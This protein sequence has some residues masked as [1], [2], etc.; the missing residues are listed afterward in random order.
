MRLGP[1]DEVGDD[2]K[3]ARIFHPFDDAQLVIEPLAILLI[4]IARAGSKLGQ[5]AGKP[6][7]RLTNEFL[8][9]RLFGRLGI[10][11]I[12]RGEARQDGRTV[13]WEI[14]AAHGDLDRIVDRFGQI[15]EKRGHLGLAFQIIIR[16][17]AS[18]VIHRNHRAFGNRHQRVMR[19]EIL[20]RRKERLVGRHQR[21]IVRVGEIDRRRFQRTV[22]I[23][24]ALEF[25][26]QPVA[27]SVFQEKQ[28]LFGDFAAVGLERRADR[29]PWTA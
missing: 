13:F 25:D 20:A 12:G 15:G 9:L 10:F 24:H 4:R 26:I 3:I 27:E 29:P 1:F 28:P 18:A 2:Q 22:V 19:V 7:M 16:R 5:P 8:R 14:R 6:L 21:Q 17:Q 23:L 11:T